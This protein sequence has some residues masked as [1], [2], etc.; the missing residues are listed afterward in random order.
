V[1]PVPAAPPPRPVPP[2]FQPELAAR[3]VVWAAD[4][5][6]RE[7][8]V[9][10]STAATLV[11]NA[12]APGLLDRYLAR[13]GY[14]S[15]QTDEPVEPDRPDNLWDPAD[16]ARDWGAHGDF[17]DRSHGRSAQWA[18]TRHRRAVLAAGTAVAGLG[19]GA[20]RAT[21]R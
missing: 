17:D 3:A 12:V 9:G 2:I 19:V 18:L 14:D 8:W 13:T 11:A 1:G 10:A 4:H 15:Q 5:D 6:R 20:W 16:D 21:R 7:W